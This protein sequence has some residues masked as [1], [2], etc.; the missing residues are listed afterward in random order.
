MPSEPNLPRR[1]V[2]HEEAFEDELRVWI[3]DAERADDFVE[4]AEYLLSADP[5]I[6]TQLEPGSNVWVLPMSPIGGDEFYLYYT[7]D[8]EYVN[9]LALRKIPFERGRSD[10]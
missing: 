9:F 2:I 10:R 5:M 1:T 6:G 7:F 4:A 3:R 8:R